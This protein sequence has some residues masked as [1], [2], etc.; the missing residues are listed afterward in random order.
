MNNQNSF[1]QADKKEI[2]NYLKKF[3]D[4]N[5]FA[6]INRGQE[7]LEFFQIEIEQ[8]P[9]ILTDKIKLILKH[10]LTIFKSDK[11]SGKL[12]VLQFLKELFEIGQ[13]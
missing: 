3:Y 4:L 7:L 10:L 11:S 8:N 5:S 1:I 13:P 2:S 6:K 12:C 9:G